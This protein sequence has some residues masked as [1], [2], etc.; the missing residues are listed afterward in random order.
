MVAV[1]VFAELGTVG[2]LVGST[3][4]CLGVPVGRIHRG[5]SYGVCTQGAM[6]VEPATGLLLSLLVLLCHGLQNPLL[7]VPLFAE[8]FTTCDTIAEPGTMGACSP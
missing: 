1:T 2:S 7:C 4:P 5:W 3:P 6:D 8:A